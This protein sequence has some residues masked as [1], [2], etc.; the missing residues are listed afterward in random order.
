MAREKQI[1]FLPVGDH[2]VEIRQMTTHSKTVIYHVL[3]T[4]PSDEF[5]LVKREEFVEDEFSRAVSLA[6][7]WG[8]KWTAV[9]KCVHCGRKITDPNLYDGDPYR[10]DVHNDP[11]PVWMCVRC[12][13]QS[14]E[15]I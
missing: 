2:W 8:A 4:L 1:E 6:K 9:H 10:E 15:D 14:A 3:E 13:R 12:R 5:T 7:I 11:T